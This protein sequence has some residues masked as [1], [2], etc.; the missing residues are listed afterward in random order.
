M[1]V[2]GQPS[3]TAR[4]R[5]ARTFRRAWRMAQTMASPTT[6]LH[7]DDDPALRRLVAEVFEDAAPDIEFVAVGDTRT[8]LDELDELR[9]P[10]VLLLDRKLPER[11]IWE[12]VD[13]AAEQL[14]R[15]TLPTFVLSGSDDPEDVAE[16]YAEGAVA[17]LEKPID[18][19]GFY[20]IARLL[21]RFTDLATLPGPRQASD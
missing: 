2:L 15:I 8:A 18:A 12:F 19:D 14:D 13:R 17:Y 4:G 1:G 16:A 21:T 5:T 6:V 7:V 20:E 3:G 10:V 11:D 9:P